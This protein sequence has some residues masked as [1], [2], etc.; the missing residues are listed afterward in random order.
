M[1]TSFHTIEATHVTNITLN[2]ADLAKMTTFTALF[3]VF[4]KST[5]RRTYYL[6]CRRK[7]SYFNFKLFS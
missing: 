4:N 5:Q 1:M 2:V 6:K 3:L 7:R